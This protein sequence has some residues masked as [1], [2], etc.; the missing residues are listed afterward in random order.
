MLINGAN[1]TEREDSVF[2]GCRR[3]WLDALR[4]NLFD[5]DI[6]KVEGLTRQESVK[7]QI[8]WKHRYHHPP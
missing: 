4:E 7:E 8:E 6:T 1:L 2:D 3:G 5:L